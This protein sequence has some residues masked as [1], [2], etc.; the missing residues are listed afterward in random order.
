MF[1]LSWISRRFQTQT[2]GWVVARN[3]L[4]HWSSE[5]K[6]WA[7][8]NPRYVSICKRWPW[9]HMKYTTTEGQL[10]FFAIVKNAPTD[11][12]DEA[13]TTALKKKHFQGNISKILCLRSIWT[14]A[15]NTAY[16]ITLDLPISATK[17]QVWRRYI[18]VAKQ[19]S[20]LG[21]EIH[22]FSWA[23]I[24]LD[25][26][27]NWQKPKLGGLNIYLI[28]GVHLTNLILILIRWTRCSFL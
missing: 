18:E 1:L 23:K 17:E 12:L 3:R 13:N 24:Q 27:N 8:L 20:Q 15:Q 21:W 2:R 10:F 14:W 25:R 28:A 7:A 19:S 9:K 6:K 4:W 22:I 16:F 26:P 5:S 11:F